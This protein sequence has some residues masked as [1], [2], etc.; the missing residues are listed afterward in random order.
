MKKILIIVILIV[1]GLLVYVYVSNRNEMIVDEDVNNVLN[2]ENLENLE[3]EPLVIEEEVAVKEFT[4]T[5]FV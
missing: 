1:I 2:L 3:E 5:S 4:M